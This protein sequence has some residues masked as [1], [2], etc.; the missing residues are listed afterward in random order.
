LK[1]KN[2]RGHHYVVTN[3]RIDNLTKQQARGL[4]RITRVLSEAKER[5]D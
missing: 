5:S 4:F 3:W 1:K 2:E